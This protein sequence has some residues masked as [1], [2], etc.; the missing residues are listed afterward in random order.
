MTDTIFEMGGNP[1][2][3][4]IGYGV[5][6]SPM[7]AAMANA[8]MAMLLTWMMTTEKAPSIPASW[9]FRP[10]WHWRKNTGSAART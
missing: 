6:T 4:V 5:K 8:T 3:T 2:S 9:Y 7:L 10:C 1:V